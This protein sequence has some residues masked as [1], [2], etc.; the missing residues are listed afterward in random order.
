M[1][2]VSSGEK[3]RENQIH[4]ELYF[5]TSTGSNYL[6][7]CISGEDYVEKILTSD[8]FGGKRP[9]ELQSR[10]LRDSFRSS[11][12]FVKIAYRYVGRAVGKHRA[13]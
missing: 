8:K 2:L 6:H 11:L 9:E 12:P 10:I 13:S 3:R 4:F 1:H 7:Q 5:L